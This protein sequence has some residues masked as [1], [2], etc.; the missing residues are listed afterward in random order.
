MVDEAKSNDGST[1]IG[2][3]LALGLGLTIAVVAAVIIIVVFVMRNRRD[4]LTLQ[5]NRF[6]GL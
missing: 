3:G 4:E 2:L 6:V 1:I 5:Q